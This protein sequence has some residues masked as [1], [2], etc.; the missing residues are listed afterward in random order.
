MVLAMPVAL[1]P[2]I[3]LDVFGVGPEGLGL[4]AAS[5]AVGAFFGAVF[6]GWVTR[7]ERVGRA[8]VLA[9]TS[10]ALAIAAFGTVTIIQ[11]GLGELSFALFG[12]ALVALAIAGASDMVSAVF[13]NTIVQLSTPDPLRGRVQSMHTL[14]VTSGPRIGDIQASVVAAVIGPGQ[15]ILAGGLLC[16][17]GVRAIDRW[18]PHLGRHV[19][20]RAAPRSGSE[21]GIGQQPAAIDEYQVPVAD[22]AAGRGA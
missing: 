3:A 6:S 13:R 17:A 12:L 2:A 18:L 11:D 5:P 21:V 10:W 19:I 22:E 20:V 16:F 8:V 14:A 15:A 4:L 7:V 9:V 1:F